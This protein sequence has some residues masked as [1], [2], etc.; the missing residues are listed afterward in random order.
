MDHA[1]ELKQNIYFCRHFFSSRTRYTHKCSA[2]LVSRTLEMLDDTEQL[3]LQPEQQ[4]ANL[5]AHRRS[6]GRGSNEKENEKPCDTGGFADNWA[7][8]LSVTAQR[9]FTVVTSSMVPTWVKQLETILCKEFNM[10]FRDPR[11]T[12]D[13]AQLRD[14]VVATAPPSSSLA[15]RKATSRLRSLTPVKQRRNSSSSVLEPHSHYPTSQF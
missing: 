9:P 2:F 3:Q 4:H 13:G 12:D 15:K 7:A 11:H 6:Q 1:L 5:W 10:Y 8:R 14:C